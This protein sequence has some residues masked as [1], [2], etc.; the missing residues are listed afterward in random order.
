MAQR[1][2]P[3]LEV[4]N[5]TQLNKANYGKAA[6]GGA[7]AVRATFGIP[8]ALQDVIAA[9]PRLKSDILDLLAD[10]DRFDGQKLHRL[11]KSLGKHKRDEIIARVDAARL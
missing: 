3:I 4:R 2:R 11:R 6:R 1:G 7:K 5:T 8:Y 9:K 10:G